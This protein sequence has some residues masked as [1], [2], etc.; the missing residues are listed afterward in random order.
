VFSPYP[1]RT[2]F[3]INLHNIYKHAPIHFGLNFVVC[4]LNTIVFGWKYL[5]PLKNKGYKTLLVFQNLIFV[6]FLNNNR[7]GYNPY[8]MFRNYLDPFTRN[9]HHFN[10]EN[11]NNHVKD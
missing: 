5:E 2:L 9:E 7:C 8:K 10:E 6:E 3:T 1:N 11:R 4:L